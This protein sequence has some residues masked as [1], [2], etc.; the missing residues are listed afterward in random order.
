MSLLFCFHLQRIFWEKRCHPTV[1]FSPFPKGALT[2]QGAFF[3]A[4]RECARLWRATALKQGGHSNEATALKQF[5]M[6]R[7]ND[8]RTGSH[9]SRPSVK[10]IW[11]NIEIKTCSAA[12]INVN[13]LYYRFIVLPA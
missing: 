7:K 11:I 9:Q 3:M 8:A 5:S 4:S 1:P 2:N 6:W 12:I 10:I 13:D